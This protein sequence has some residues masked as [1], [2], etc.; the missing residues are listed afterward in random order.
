MGGT[1]WETISSVADD[2]RAGSEGV[3]NGERVF[4]ASG[5]KICAEIAETVW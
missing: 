5:L 3:S 2:I 1:W 4:F